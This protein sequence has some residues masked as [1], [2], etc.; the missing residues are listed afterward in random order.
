MRVHALITAPEYNV[1]LHARERKANV[2]KQAPQVSVKVVV[3][4]LGWAIHALSQLWVLE[5]NLTIR[6]ELMD[7]VVIRLV[8]EFAIRLLIQVTFNKSPTCTTT[9]A[10]HFCS[11]FIV[12]VFIA[13][14]NSRPSPFHVKVVPRTHVIAPPV[15]FLGVGVGLSTPR[16]FLLTLAT[17]SILLCVFFAKGRT[18][19]IGMLGW[20][21]LR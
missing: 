18:W 14:L 13:L 4:F 1:K 6:A 21:S 11:A 17:A 3:V 9:P 15:I 2:T 12:A 10:R 8:Y 7:A 5:I 19:A 20:W 16:V